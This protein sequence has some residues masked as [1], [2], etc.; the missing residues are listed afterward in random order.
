[1]HCERFS[2]RTRAVGGGSEDEN[3]QVREREQTRKRVV[4]LLGLAVLKEKS[5]VTAKESGASDAVL[6]AAG[7]RIWLGQFDRGRDGV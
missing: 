2:P 4:L 7:F 5:L 1:M 6:H 3:L